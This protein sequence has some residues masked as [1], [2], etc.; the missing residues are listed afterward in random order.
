MNC[1][2]MA[3]TVTFSSVVSSTYYVRNQR[4]NVHLHLL[5]LHNLIYYSILS[6]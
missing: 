6:V 3:K 1:Y 4:M 2:Y 5:L